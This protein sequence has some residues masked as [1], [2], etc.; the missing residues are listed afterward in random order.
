VK[1]SPP[2]LSLKLKSSGGRARARR[3]QAK[4]RQEKTSG[5][6][7]EGGE[8]L[9]ECKRYRLSGIVRPHQRGTVPLP[10]AISRGEE[11]GGENG[12]PGQDWAS[13]ERVRRK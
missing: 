13:A 8:W 12:K 6:E 2:A 1:S 10:A 4:I 7:Q 3:N 9:S 11:D 5:K